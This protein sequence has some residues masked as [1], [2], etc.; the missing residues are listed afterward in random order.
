MRS[1]QTCFMTG[2]LTRGLSVS[3]RDRSG[4]KDS[5][6][7]DLPKALAVL[8]K[9]TRTRQRRLSLPEIANWLDRAVKGFGSLKEVADRIGLSTKMLRQFEYVRQ[10]SPSVQALFAQRKLDSVDTAVHLSRLSAADQITIAQGIAKGQ[11][12]SA[13]VRAIAELRRKRLKGDID[14]LLHRVKESKNVKQYLAEFVVRSKKA[15]PDSLRKT[16]G[17]IIGP[18]SICSIDIKGS[19]GTLK[20]T[21]QGRDRLQK[22]ATSKGLTKAALVTRLTQRQEE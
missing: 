14:E 7:A 12:D 16:F 13:D 15:T 3:R 11:L 6:D 20:M 19:I 22:A 10:L 2:S 4:G 18:E 9:N 17:R 21:A 5:A 8:I 1:S